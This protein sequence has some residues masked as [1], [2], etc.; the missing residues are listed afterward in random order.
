MVH[1]RDPRSMTHL[2]LPHRPNRFGRSPLLLSLLRRSRTCF[3][4]FMS[5]LF[6]SFIIRCITL[7]RRSREI[8]RT[9]M[10]DDCL[11]WADKHP[12]PTSR[13]HILCSASSQ[14]SRPNCTP[15]LV[16]FSNIEI[17]RP[18]PVRR[19]SSFGRTKTSVLPRLRAPQLLH[20][21]Q[22]LFGEESH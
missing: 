6:S 15:L 21:K 10:A 5:L 8:C 12:S 16:C 9:L 17:E 2:S 13:T 4:R 19:V 14:V 7:L 1:D 3:R 20:E 22:P 11:I 18:T